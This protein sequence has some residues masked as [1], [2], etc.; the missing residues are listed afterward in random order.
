LALAGLIGAGLLAAAPRAAPCLQCQPL[1]AP[2]GA[3]A[4]SLAVATALV[5]VL[6]A[7]GGWQ[8]TNFIAEE[9]IQPERNLPRAL[10]F[11]VVVVVAVYLLANLAYLRVLGVE[12]LARSGAP[13]ADAMARVL[14]QRGRQGISLGI[15]LST[16]GF[17][18]TVI[19]VSP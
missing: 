15:M 19:L 9:I 12:G 6:F 14:G 18:N 8:Q 13:A 17:L 10:V 1:P 3:G 11:G 5:P 4:A 16:F 7:Y 2:N